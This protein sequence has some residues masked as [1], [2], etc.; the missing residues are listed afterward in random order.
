MTT[1]QNKKGGWC[2]FAYGVFCQKGYCSGCVIGQKWERNHKL[3]MEI[4][5][6]N[7][8]LTVEVSRIGRN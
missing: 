2:P 4:N 6:N 8:L 1:E 7:G 5:K 3:D